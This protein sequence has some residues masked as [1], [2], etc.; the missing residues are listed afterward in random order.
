MFAFVLR[1]LIY[2][3]L[4]LLIISMASFVMVEAPPGNALTAEIQR[5]RAQGGE[6]SQDQI[7]ALEVRYGVNDPIHEKYWQWASGFVRGDF[8]Y[9]FDRKAPVA[10]L[11]WGRVGYSVMLSLGALLVAWLIAI[12]VGVYSATHRYSLPDYIITT[13]QFIGIA[14]PEF[15]LALLV[16]VFASRYFGIDVGGL[17]SREYQTA[18]WSFGKL[19]DLLSHLW[20]PLLVISA[21]GTAWLTRVMR[22][23]LLDVLNQQYVQTARA[24]GVIERGVIWKHAVRNAFHPLVMALGGVLPALIGGEAIVSI[25]LNLPTIGPMF[26]TS[27]TEQDLYLSATLLVVLSALLIIGN[28]LADILLAWLDPRVRTVE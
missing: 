6:V 27:L 19:L 13:I 1:R 18:P 22:A 10:D 11:I 23:N 16:L 20:I 15:L 14:I 2:G 17:F 7:Q 8:G 5:L 4:T 3:L 28:L 24:K 12:P 26:I 9:S 25:V 21:G